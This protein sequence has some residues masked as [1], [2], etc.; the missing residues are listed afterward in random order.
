MLARQGCFDVARL[1]LNVLFVIAGLLLQQHD[2]LHDV[3]EHHHRHSQHGSV[4]SW[5]FLFELPGNPSFA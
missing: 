4:I 2:R 1:E 3:A 5:R